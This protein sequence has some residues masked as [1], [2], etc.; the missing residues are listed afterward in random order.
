MWANEGASTVE[1]LMLAGTAQLAAAM[2]C[3][4]AT[5]L[6]VTRKA[7]TELMTS[8]TRLHAAGIVHRDVKPANLIAAEVGRMFV[9][10]HHCVCVPCLSRPAEEP[11][12]RLFVTA[13]HVTAILHVLVPQTQSIRP[14][15]KSIRI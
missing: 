14:W 6:G 12:D 5:E 4:D 10:A 15:R 13:C 3:A 11:G 9:T 7:M 8:L 2:G 1:Q